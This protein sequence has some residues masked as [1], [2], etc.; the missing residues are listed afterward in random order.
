MKKLLMLNVVF[1]LL[2][3]LILSLAGP[4]VAQDNEPTKVAGSF[5]IDQSGPGQ[6]IPRGSIVR[7][8]ENGIT[9]VYKRDNSLMMRS[10]DLEAAMVATPSGLARAT[11]VYVVP[12][13]S[14]INTR[15]NTTD[16]YENNTLILRVIDSGV[17][18]VPQFS[19][20]IEQANNWSVSNLDYFGAN[21]V[22]P[23]RPPGP[24]TDVV[25]FLFNAIEPQ[26]GSAIIQPVLEWNQA[27]SGGWTLRSWYGPVNGNYYCS[28]PVAASSGNSISGV[29][30]YSR[31]LGCQ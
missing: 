14:E 4:V 31:L 3:G 21:W 7:H 12:S 19:G 8:L 27:G 16:V 17:L 9:E 25:D 13:G 29:M 15:G 20:W 6:K 24:G 30:S 28:S 5:S 26:T 2:I 11:H 23:S 22:V 1:L 10:L 18:A